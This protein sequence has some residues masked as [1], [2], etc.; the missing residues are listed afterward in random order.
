M[1]LHIKTK[2]L[3]GH[4]IEVAMPA[5]PIG[6]SVDVIVITGEK[7]TSQRESILDVIEK[8]RR[9]HPHRSAEEIDTN[10]QE[11]RNSWDN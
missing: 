9:R 3:P 2:I 6:E 4:K 7:K 10:L 11:Q 1:N 8:I 5:L